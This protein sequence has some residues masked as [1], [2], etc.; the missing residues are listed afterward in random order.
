MPYGPQ[1]AIEHSKKANTPAKKKKWAHIA[2]AAL[3]TYGE[4]GVGKAIATANA[5]MGDRWW[6]Q[7]WFDSS[8][9]RQWADVRYRKTIRRGAT[10]REEGTFEE[11]VDDL[12]EEQTSDSDYRRP[13]HDAVYDREFTSKQRKSA[14][15]SGAAMAGGGF[16]INSK[17]DLANARQA[18]GRAKNRA[19]TIAHI[20]KRAKA[21]GVKLPENWPNDADPFVSRVAQPRFV[22][23][24]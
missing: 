20:K 1:N 21:L 14:A 9:F 22:I 10:G 6:P 8:A 2:N 24:R 23:L 16:P 12:D 11:E 7:G 3:K 4:K 5:A 15:E 13:F 17:A 19:A 18:L